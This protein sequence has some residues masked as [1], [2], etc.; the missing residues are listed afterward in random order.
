MYV[1][2]FIDD[3]AGYMKWVARNPDGFVLNTY[4]RP[5]PGYLKLHRATCRTIN[6]HPARG[7]RWTADYQK[8]CG[9]RSELERWQENRFTASRNRAR[10]ALR[11][12]ATGKMICAPI[13]LPM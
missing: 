13:L 3:D 5:S 8:I 7:D 1:E 6:D 12:G 4:R 2:R 10:L 9:S 11:N